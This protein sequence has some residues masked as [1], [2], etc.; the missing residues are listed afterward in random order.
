MNYIFQYTA[1]ANQRHF[2]YVKFMVIQLKLQ[3]DEC[4]R[5][6][7]SALD[8]AQCVINNIFARLR[9]NIDFHIYTNYNQRM[10]ARR[11]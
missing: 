10:R 6:I 1:R 2:K 5:A 8:S 4:A 7:L 11:I 3:R 9:L